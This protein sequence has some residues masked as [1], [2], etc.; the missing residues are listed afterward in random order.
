M[1]KNAEPSVDVVGLA[2][3]ANIFV[4]PEEAEKYQGQIVE[5]LLYVKN[6]TTLTLE[7][8]VGKSSVF[9]NS[10]V[11]FEDGLL[12]KRGLSSDE[13]VLNA[14]RKTDNYFVVEKIL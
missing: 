7:H 12:N 5:T 8:N 14:N 6:L 1:P 10:T 2:T 11:M 4:T 9:E 3:L 13:A